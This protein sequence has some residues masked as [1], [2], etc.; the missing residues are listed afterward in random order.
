[1]KINCQSC[2]GTGLYKGIFEPSGTAVVCSTCK[3]TGAQEVPTDYAPAPTT[4]YAGRKLKA[5]ISRVE[6]SV[7]QFQ[8]FFPEAPR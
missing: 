1:M 3:G 4:A 6:I 7:E 8:R 2:G 5:G